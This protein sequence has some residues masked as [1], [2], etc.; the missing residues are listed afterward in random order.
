[1]TIWSSASF[2]RIIGWIQLV[3]CQMGSTDVYINTWMYGVYFSLDKYT[4]LLLGYSLTNDSTMDMSHKCNISIILF[5]VLKIIK[6]IIL[7]YMNTMQCYL[8]ITSSYVGDWNV[9]YYYGVA[10][11][12]L[13]PRVEHYIVSLKECLHCY[14]QTLGTVEKVILDSIFLYSIHVYINKY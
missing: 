9:H 13:Y 12:I 1:M 4:F 2:I 7:K 5:L 6:L 3:P 14:I 10:H 11:C 8:K